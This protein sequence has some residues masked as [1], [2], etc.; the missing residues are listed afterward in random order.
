MLSVNGECTRVCK[1]MVWACMCVWQIICTYLAWCGCP[2]VLPIMDRVVTD[3]TRAEYT[4][5]L[6]DND[7]VAK[8]S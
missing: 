8:L 1:R 5:Y 3:V 2:Q 4:T 6:Q 7:S